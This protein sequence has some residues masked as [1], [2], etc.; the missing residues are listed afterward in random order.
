ME[1][2][3]FEIGQFEI[4]NRLRNLCWTVSGD[5]GLNLK[6]GSRPQNRLLHKGKPDLP[7]EG[8]SKPGRRRKSG[9]VP[10]GCWLTRKRRIKCIPILS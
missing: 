2:E 7:D 6:H 9:Y 5:Y 4:E 3:A 1:E 8:R 10:N